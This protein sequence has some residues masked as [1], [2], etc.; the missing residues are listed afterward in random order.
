MLF[1]YLCNLLY[2]YK[3]GPINEVENQENCREENSTILVQ[4]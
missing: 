1:E 4:L 3:I 2:H